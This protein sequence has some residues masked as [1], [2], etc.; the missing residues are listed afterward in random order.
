MAAFGC[1]G[2]RVN[3]QSP[4]NEIGV[5]VGVWYVVVQD[6]DGHCD[7]D[8]TTCSSSSIASCLAT[9]PRAA[10]SRAASAS[11]AGGR[12]SQDLSGSPVYQQVDENEGSQVCASLISDPQVMAS[13]AEAGGLEDL[14]IEV[15]TAAT[16][17]NREGNSRTVV[18]AVCGGRIVTR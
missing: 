7:C 5:S 4:G 13:M 18:Y 12:Y 14:A 16:S 6:V 9:R 3:F 2:G 8:R 17:T 10:V 15:R 11:C 1:V